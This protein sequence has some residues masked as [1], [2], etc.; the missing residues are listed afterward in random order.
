MDNGE[1]RQPVEATKVCEMCGKE[2][3]IVYK[4]RYSLRSSKRKYCPACLAK[5][6]AENSRNNIMRVRKRKDSNQKK[7]VRERE[8]ALAI[9]NVAVSIVLDAID[10]ER[11]DAAAQI[12]DVQ[13]VIDAVSY[14]VNAAERY[15][16]MG[17]RDTSER[18]SI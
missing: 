4:D 1:I 18:E 11:R 10:R 16:K 6:A 2:Y 14:G 17:R 7:K 12:Y 15:M 9:G 3:T 5:L 13:S 8:K